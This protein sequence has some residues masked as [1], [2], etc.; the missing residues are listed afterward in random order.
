MV[1]DN[2]SHA[3]NPGDRS[4]VKQGKVVVVM[5]AYNAQNTLEQTLSDISPGL[6]DEVILVDDASRDSTVELARRLGVR[7]IT[8]EKNTGYGS[9]QKTCYRAALESGASIIV[10]LHPDYQYDP[11]LIPYLIGPIHLGIC[12]IMLGNRIRTRKEALAGGMPVYK[13]LS[14][15]ILTII[16]NLCLGQNLGEF[17]SGYRA[18]SRKVLETIPWERNSNDFVFD[19]EFLIQAIHFGFR[20]GDAPCPVRYFPEASSINWHRSVRYGT[21]TLLTLAKY[22][23][24]RLGIL[25]SPLFEG[26]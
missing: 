16:E 26:K 12:D 24:H 14:N 7:V 17:H 25:R 13:Y 3:D 22:L 15:R 6:V 8:H 18:Y 11:R 19:Q 4:T 21:E 5:P 23:L 1:V 20:I 9:N 2:R 10:M